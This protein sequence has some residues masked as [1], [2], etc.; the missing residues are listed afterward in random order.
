[1]SGKHRTYLILFIIEGPIDKWFWSSTLT[2]TTWIK[3]LRFPC[4]WLCFYL[5]KCFS[6][7]M[8]PI[9]VIWLTRAFSSNCLFL[10]GP[11]LAFG[12]L[13]SAVISGAGGGLFTGE[14]T[15]GQD[16]VLAG[17]NFHCWRSHTLSSHFLI[18]RRQKSRVE[19]GN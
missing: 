13:T 5:L 11:S 1:M 19:L 6:I 12:D 18:W 4:E 16:R 10:V 7:C 9:A 14:C 8:F 3:L 2:N 15:L 17:S